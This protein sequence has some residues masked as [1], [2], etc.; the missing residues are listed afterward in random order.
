M[1]TYIDDAIKAIN[2]GLQEPDAFYAKTKLIATSKW[3]STDGQRGYSRL[4]PE[5]GYKIVKSSWLTGNWSDAPYG[6]SETEVKSEIEKLEKEYGNV[7]VIFTTTSNVFSTSY[8]V[9][10]RNSEPLNKE[11]QGKA[12]G[13][14]TKLFE[15]A[16]SW[17]VRYHATDVISYNA[18]T[19][20]YTLDSGGWDTNTTKKRINAYLPT[21]YYITQRKFEWYLQTPAGEIKFVDNMKIKIP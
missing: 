20:E 4:T 8:D 5:Q 21:G 10:I 2:N 12:V 15:N 6:H 19:N 9:I 18:K 7:Y 3:H 1:I 13:H 11:T 16:D 14:K 17:R